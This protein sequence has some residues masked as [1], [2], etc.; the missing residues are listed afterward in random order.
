MSVTS[1]LNKYTAILVDDEEP[2]RSQLRRLLT[3]IPSVSLVAEA[4]NPFKCLELIE[5]HTPQL[6]FL[7]I[8]MPGLNGFEMLKQIP[9][10]DLPLIIFI[11]AFDQYALKAFDSLAIDYLLKP[12]RLSDLQKAISKIDS[13]EN[14]FQKSKH[15]LDP[16]KQQDNPL[17]DYT[18]QFVLRYGR[19][20]SIIDEQDVVMFFSEDKFCYLRSN[21][22][23]SIINFTLQELEHKLDPNIFLRIH[24]STIVSRHYIN[25]IKSIGSGRHEVML[26]DGKIVHSSRYYAQNIKKL[27]ST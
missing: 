23:D 26:N 5:L 17:L 2:A 8:Q 7:D 14:V 19:K 3:Q 15:L 6:L 18:K 4:E 11:T 21:G 25:S 27:I 24:R 13:L 9:P 20:W 16:E 12:L 1:S 22:R 10:G